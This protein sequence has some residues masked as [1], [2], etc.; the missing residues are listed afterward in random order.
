M[1][2]FIS[3]N[4]LLMSRAQWVWHTRLESVEFEILYSYEHVR[5][6]TMIE[7]SEDIEETNCIYGYWYK[8][9][10]FV[11]IFKQE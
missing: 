3:L 4:R 8:I 10:Y 11:F 9:S 2:L 5:G 7:I 6:A 1:F